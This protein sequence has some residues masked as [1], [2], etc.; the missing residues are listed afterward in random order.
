[1][2]ILQENEKP[3]HSWDGQEINLGNSIYYYIGRAGS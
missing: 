2:I 1:M 3:N